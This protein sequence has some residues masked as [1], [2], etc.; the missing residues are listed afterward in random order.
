[1]SKI[2]VYLPTH[3]RVQLLQR[4]IQSVLQ[5]THT[6]LELIVVDAGST[7]ETAT[8]LHELAQ[9]DE[10]LLTITLPEK[11]PAPECRNLAIKKAT[12]DFVTGLDDDDYFLPGRLEELLNAYDD[13]YAFVCSTLLEQTS[14]GEQTQRYF[15]LKA[16]ELSLDDLLH[17]NIVGNQVFT[18]RDKWLAIGGFDEQMPSFQDYDTWVRLMIKYPKALKLAKA[19]YVVDTGH[20]SERISSVTERRL[21]GFERFYNKHKHLMTNSH[22]KSMM[23]MQAKLSGEKL[24]IFK[25]L[26]LLSRHNFK[27]SLTMFLDSYLPF[28]N[29]LK[30]RL[31]KQDA[32]E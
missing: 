3:N 22:R 32:Y 28:V 25:H 31:R 29:R 23:L 20:D 26:R 19:S 12:G 6:N 17:H 27:V 24:S 9:S 21:A 11:R 8:V 10:R 1:M 14:T 2:S 18:T 5:Q 4:A 13:Q 30:D 7:D 16:G 15:G